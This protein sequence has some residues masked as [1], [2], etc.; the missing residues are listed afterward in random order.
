MSQEFKQIDK[1]DLSRMSNSGGLLATI[2]LHSKTTVIAKL[3]FRDTNVPKKLKMQ[4]Y[5]WGTVP[6]IYY[7]IEAFPHIVDIL[8]NEKPVWLTYSV[9]MGYARI[10]TDAEPIGEGEDS[11]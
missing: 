11:T 7:P 2:W 10:T 8:R 3:E 5:Q 1:Y 9:S 4:Q 6:F